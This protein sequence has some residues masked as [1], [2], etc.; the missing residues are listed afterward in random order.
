MDYAK[1]VM[2]S[3]SYVIHLSILKILCISAMNV[4]MARLRDGVWYAVVW[5]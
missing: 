2:E 1:N 4:I 5:V 3:V